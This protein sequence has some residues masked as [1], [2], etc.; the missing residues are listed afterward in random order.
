MKPVHVTILCIFSLIVFSASQATA[1]VSLVLEHPGQAQV[2]QEIDVTVAL[3]GNDEDNDPA[4]ICSFEYWLQFDPEVLRPVGNQTEPFF[5]P[6][7]VG[8]QY[9]L[10]AAT[11]PPT[12][13]LCTAFGVDGSGTGV[14]WPYDKDTATFTF[15]VL[16]G[17]ETSFTLFGNDNIVTDCNLVEPTSVDIENVI[18]SQINKKP[19]PAKPVPTI[20]EYGMIILSL[21]LA[22]SAFI[23]IRRKD[24]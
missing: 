13:D 24:I 18:N 5:P 6:F 20:S 22:L 17:Q 12:Q 11:D 19:A 7:P 10:F 23:Y 16:S 4:K 15:E 9:A 14:A 1:T 2:G 3:R 8:V 21:L